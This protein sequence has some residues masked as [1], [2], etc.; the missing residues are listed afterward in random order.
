MPTLVLKL[1]FVIIPSQ[2]PFFVRPI[3]HMITSRVQHMFI[4]PDLSR[5]IQFVSDSLGKKDASGRAWFAG[6]DRDGNPTS[7]DYQMLFP[8]EAIT[9]GRMPA[10]TAVP[11]SIKT[12]VEWVHSRPAYKRA[13]EKGGAYDYAKL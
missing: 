8:M 11:D 12:W 2:A 1:V 13:Y 4:D 3:V 9:S 10:S 6:G 5:K 7:A